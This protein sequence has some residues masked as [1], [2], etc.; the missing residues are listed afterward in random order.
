VIHIIISIGGYMKRGIIV[1]VSIVTLGMMVGC[2]G[3]EK[4][5]E[6]VSQP[7]PV[8][9]GP[10]YLGKNVVLA[11]VIWQHSFS[12]ANFFPCSLVSEKNG[13]Y[14]VITLDGSPDIELG[15]T[16]TSSIVSLRSHPAQPEELKNGNVVMFIDENYAMPDE[17]LKEGH[18]R[19]GIVMNID[20]ADSLV[21]VG[22]CENLA[23]GIQQEHRVHMKNLRISDDP[24]FKGL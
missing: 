14:E 6:P 17:E 2:G 21:S 10:D 15:G 8:Y 13:M 16:Y 20:K 7:A 9:Q 1:C 22:T 18:W 19:R 24:V 12:E 4:P 11:A 5:P 23:D 3:G